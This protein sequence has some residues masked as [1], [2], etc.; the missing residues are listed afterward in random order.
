MKAGGASR[1]AV[2]V[3]QGRAVADGRAA[4]GRFSDPV[5]RR[6][7]RPEELEPVDAARDGGRQVEGRERWAVES[8]RACA[9]VMVPR[10]V[11][12]DDALTDAVEGRGIRQVVLL[13]AGLDGRPWRL[14]A[15]GAATVFCVDH[16]AS[17]ADARERAAGLDPVAG[18]LV[19]AGVDL[20]SQ[21]L[22]AALE[23]AGHR[24]TVPTAW[25]WEGVVPYLRKADVAATASAVARRSAAGSVLAVNYQTP[26]L[27]AKIG[28]IVVDL[29]AR[30][31]R[32]EAAT[33]DE[34]WRSAW[35]PAAMADLV[36]ARG[37]V[38]EDDVDLLDV[39]RRLD[40]PTAHSRSVRNGR[41]AI[42]RFSTTATGA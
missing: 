42:A 21:P 4:V 29:A 38:V 14:E 1:T 6:L 39:A 16:P 17:Q 35:T 5:A 31:G 7:L 26:S 8:V 27:M 12:I 3:C 20:T 28:R 36:T 18:E 25:V 24:R 40:S 15:L 34:P 13:G 9:E 30:A 2:F 23:A 37:F 41:V 19:F 32:V 11:T 33:A 22:D 10:T